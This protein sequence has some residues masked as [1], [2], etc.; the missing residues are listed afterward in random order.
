MPLGYFW[1]GED[2]YRP[3]VSLLFVRV[4]ICRR[5]RGVDGGKGAAVNGVAEDAEKD[6]FHNRRYGT[7]NLGYSSYPSYST[8]LLLTDRQSKKVFKIGDRRRGLTDA[9]LKV[10]KHR[11]G[12]KVLGFFIDEKTTLSRSTLNRYFPE[13]DYY[14]SVIKHLTE[15]KLLLNLEK[16]KF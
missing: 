14:E 11:T 2:L 5:K 3:P 9:V 8:N 16:T 1:R 4:L 10:L 12:S 7:S 15:K 13:Y 6:K